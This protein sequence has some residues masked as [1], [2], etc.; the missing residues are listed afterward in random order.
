MMKYN[1]NFCHL[2]DKSRLT[3]P[4]ANQYKLALLSLNFKNLM[5]NNIKFK[6]FIHSSSIL[7]SD[8]LPQE[9]LDRVDNINPQTIFADPTTM[10]Q[11]NS[12]IIGEVARL[13]NERLSNLKLV[14][15]KSAPEK[16]EDD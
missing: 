1:T 5:F 13:E 2:L 3:Y 15:Y 16:E 4:F 7:K 14:K 12:P 11:S 10:T 9:N 8:I 6:T